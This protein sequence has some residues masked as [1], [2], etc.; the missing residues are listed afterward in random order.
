MPADFLCNVCEAIIY[1]N[2]KNKTKSARSSEISSRIWTIQKP[3]RNHSKSQTIDS[4]NMQ[5][6]PSFK[7]TFCGSE[8]TKKE[9]PRIAL[10]EPKTLKE[11]LVQEAHGQMLSGH[12]VTSKTK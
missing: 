2:C 11:N 5:M 4:S 3:I 6:N 7:R 8:S 10:F 1:Q 12:D 9:V